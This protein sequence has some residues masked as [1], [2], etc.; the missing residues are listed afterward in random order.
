MKNREEIV[1]DIIKETTTNIPQI[2]SYKTGGVFRL[3]VEVVASFLES[4]YTEMEELLPNRFVQTATSK[5]LD[6]KAEELSLYRYEASKT[7]GYVSFYR[8]DSE[9]SV[10]IPKGKILASKQGLRFVVVEECVIPSGENSL[11]VLIE[12]EEVGTLYNVYSSDQITEFITPISGIDSVTNSN[13]WIVEVGKDEESDES[14]RLRCSSL[15]AGISGSNKEA[16]VNW[17]KSI[18]D[19]GD[20]QVVA[21]PR[22]VGTVDVYCLGVDNAYPSEEMILKVQEYIDER[23]PIST[24]VMV[25]SALRTDIDLDLSVVTLPEY[26]VTEEQVQEI[27]EEFFKD[28]KMADDFESSALISYIFELE[29]IKSVTINTPQRTTIS[30]GC[31][32]S[33]S[34]L[35][36][37]I[38][39]STEN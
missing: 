39:T 14:L 30:D 24:S 26:N 37:N 23:K 28:M 33:L 13:A 4:I 20:V 22:G 7:Q 16:Y 38:T 1:E 15:W 35:T 11:S 36:M 34:N 25:F 9:K 31:V 27:V 32:A 10:T 21:T 2:T 29:G 17:A 8:E 6:L 18:E 19:I 12:A 5:W 3:F